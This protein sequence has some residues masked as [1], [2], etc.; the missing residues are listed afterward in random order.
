MARAACLNLNIDI[1]LIY[2]E[3]GGGGGAE[4]FPYIL[5]FHMNTI[6][7]SITYLLTL[8]KKRGVMSLCKIPLG[9]FYT[10]I[11]LMYTFIDILEIDYTLRQHYMK[12][13]YSD[14]VS[15]LIPHIL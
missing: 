11:A 2:R 12:W 14:W 6:V 3:N 1:S 5:Q 13:S 8:Q 9:Q 10:I 4:T 15:F 7:H